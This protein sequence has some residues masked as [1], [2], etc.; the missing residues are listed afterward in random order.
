MLSEWQ[1]GR[2]NYFQ[3]QGNLR[4]IFS[5]QHVYSM[6]LRQP[7]QAHAVLGLFV[8]VSVTRR[9]QRDFSKEG[10]NISR[11]LRQVNKISD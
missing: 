1:V 6:F 10:L 11:A 7:Y 2:T 9:F 5:G 8:F 3:N 4:V